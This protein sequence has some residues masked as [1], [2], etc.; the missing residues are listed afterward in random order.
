M[1]AALYGAIAVILAAAVTGYVTWLVASRAKSGK[2]DTSE[3]ATLWQEG[4]TMRKELRDEVTSLKTQLTAAITAITDL[5]REI[6]ASRAE[7]ERSREETRKSRAE[8]R[9]LMAQI[10][11]LHGEVKTSNALTMGAL[12][13]NQETRRI[14]LLPKEERT[15]VEF[16]HLASVGERQPESDHPVIPPEELRDSDVQIEEE[17]S[18]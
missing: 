16:E 11:E 18:K 12:A 13:D 1:T 5:N 10:E 15:P 9:R 4:T 6:K 7:T 8:T 2:I 17:E 3:A 14:L